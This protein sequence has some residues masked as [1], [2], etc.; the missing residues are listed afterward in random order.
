MKKSGDKDKAKEKGDE[1][2]VDVLLRYA[3]LNLL[4]VG[5][6]KQPE[7]IAGHAAWV[8]AKVGNRTA[9][10]RLALGHRR[11]RPAHLAALA[12]AI[13]ALTG[14][15]ALAFF[16]AIAPIVH[17]ESIDLDKAW[18]QSR[19]DKA[20][21]ADGADYIN[22]PMDEAQYRRLHRRAARRAKRP[23]SRTGRK[24]RPISKAACRSR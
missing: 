1:P 4:Y 23:S 7:V 17:R 10:R 11:H 24:T 14:E 13:H 16:D 3:K 18:F 22:C 20:G 6:I 21:P 8:R 15:D 2:E 12:D 9:A 19:Y 5:W